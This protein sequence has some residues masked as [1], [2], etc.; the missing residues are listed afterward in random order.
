MQAW[1]L[2]PALASGCTVVMKVSNKTPL[3]ALHVCKLIAEVFFFC[4]K[5]LEK[6]KL[7]LIFRLDFHQE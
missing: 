7:L 4:L 1:K 6:L 3:S 2:G 5:V